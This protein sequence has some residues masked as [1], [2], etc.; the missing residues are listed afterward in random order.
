ME[1][2]SARVLL[3]F[4]FWINS[5]SENTLLIPN[6]KDPDKAK[7]SYWCPNQPDANRLMLLAVRGWKQLWT[8]HSHP[9]VRSFGPAFCLLRK[10]RPIELYFVLIALTW[11][12]GTQRSLWPAREES[13]TET[14]F[15][16]LSWTDVS[17]KA[18]ALWDN[19]HND[20][21]SQD[22]WHLEK[23]CSMN[24]WTIFNVAP[25]NGMDRQNTAG[26]AES[27]SRAMHLKVSHKTQDWMALSWHDGNAVVLHKTRPLQALLATWE[28]SVLQL[29]QMWSHVTSKSEH[30][31][32]MLQSQ[33][34]SRGDPFRVVLLAQLTRS[35]SWIVHTVGTKAFHLQF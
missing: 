11:E 19:V 7:N 30:I 1:K 29:R 5:F 10:M 20:Y 24:C 32:L 21:M 23:W 2:Q 28:D 22:T 16:R 25:L 34:V 13:W 4:A 31:V 27:G 9:R 35:H 18:T 8:L 33:I 12:N 17:K 15:L 6:K 26:T 3:S 14:R